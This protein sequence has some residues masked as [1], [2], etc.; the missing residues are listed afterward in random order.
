MTEVVMNGKPVEILLVEDSPS[1]IRLTR[2]GFRKVRMANNLHV[3]TDGEQ[4]LDFVFQRGEHEN[5]PQPDLILLDLNLPKV[6][7]REVLKEIKEDPLLRKI[8]VI[9]LTTSD[10]D[11][12]IIRAY[13]LHA[14]AYIQKPVQFN[15]FVDVVARI[16]GFWLSVV[17]YP[18]SNGT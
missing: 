9:V 15:D 6:H 17:K 8:P 7:G 5:A 11:Q 1:D 16:E 13:D 4:A 2:E 12:D 18:R 10:N 3:A 14:N